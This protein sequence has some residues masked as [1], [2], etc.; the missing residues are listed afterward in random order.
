M[1][2]IQKNP[3]QY[4]QAD[5]YSMSRSQL[6]ASDIGSLDLVPLLFQ[7][8]YLTIDSLDKTPEGL[9]S[10]DDFIL[11]SPNQEVSQAFG[12][13]ILETLTKQEEKIIAKVSSM[14][15]K[16]L[17][18]CDNFLLSEAFREVLTWPMGMEQI[19]HEKYCQSI[20][21]IFL[22]TLSYK[23]KA[24]DSTYKGWTDLIIHFGND[25]VFIIE[26]KYEK[27]DEPEK[28]TPAEK[29]QLLAKNLL[30][31]KNQ[32]MERNY[33]HDYEND[34]LKVKNIAVAIVGR[35]DVEVEFF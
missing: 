26:F 29:S 28:V 3:M 4:I 6:D 7:T 12:S 15:K 16:A 9:V 2:L 11:R 32:I 17:T 25:T 30:V 10:V 35:E 21:H 13:L 14:V 33:A 8:G 20:F 23:V 18:N 24:E 1:K 22:K 31:A 34:D 27:L 19:Q 5:T